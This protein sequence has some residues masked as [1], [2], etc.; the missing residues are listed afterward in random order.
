ML[1]Y[2]R[3]TMCLILRIFCSKINSKKRIAGFG[4]ELRQDRRKNVY[5][6]DMT[7]FISYDTISNEDS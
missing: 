5:A 6:I 1:K 2:P 3:N 4:A 7:D